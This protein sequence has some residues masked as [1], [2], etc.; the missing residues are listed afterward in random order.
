MYVLEINKIRKRCLESFIAEN[1]LENKLTILEKSFHEL[2]QTDYDTTKFNILL[3]ELAFSQA[4]LPWENLYFYYGCKN[5]TSLT[6]SNEI[7]FLPERIVLKAIA[8]EYENLD[9]IRSHVNVC[10]GFNLAEFDKVILE[11]SRNSD[12]FQEPHPLW[13]YP[14][15]PLSHAHEIFRFE[16]DPKTLRKSTQTKEIEMP[17]VH[18]GVLNGVALWQE[19]VYDHENELNCGLL[20][21]PKQNEN[22][23][24]SMN[25]KQAVHLFDKKHSINHENK[26]NLSLRCSVKFDIGLGKFNV[27]FKI[28]ELN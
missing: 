3:S 15:K 4:L 28:K 12:G 23:V 13:E 2:S 1:N 21:L 9:K 24:W 19:I 7:K 6:G 14:C 5:V 11:A 26:A 25:Y 17:L 27:D 8:V 20:E 18:E 16:F 22:L 10:E